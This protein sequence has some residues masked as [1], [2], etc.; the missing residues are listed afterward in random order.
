MKK[1]LNFINGEHCAT[2]LTFDKRSPLTGQVIAR[3]HQA[4]RPEVDAA[5]SAAHRA[6]RGPWSRMSIEQRA[7]RLYAVADGI[8]RRFDEF[9]AAECEDTGKPM[10][11]A[12]HLDI[13]RGAANFLVIRN[14][15]LIE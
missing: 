10:S 13:P 5:V 8:N 9:L 2:A 3:V 7:E 11:L 1:I 6:L 4:G 15:R 14:G 12:R